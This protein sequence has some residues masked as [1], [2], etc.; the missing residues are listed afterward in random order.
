MYSRLT[1]LFKVEGKFAL[2]DK[3]WVWLGTFQ[4]FNRFGEQQ[5]YTEKKIIRYVRFTFLETYGKWSYFTLTQVKIRGNGLFAD[6][7]TEIT[8]KKYN[9]FLGSLDGDDGDGEGDFSTSS[10]SSHYSLSATSDKATH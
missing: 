1:K 5:F 2:D 9:S 4:A 10:A 8:G 7:L 3:K 6:A